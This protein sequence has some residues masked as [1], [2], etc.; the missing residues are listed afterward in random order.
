MVVERDASGVPQYEIAVYEDITARRHAEEALR[1]SE[2][3]FR[4]TFEL[5]DSGL[6][7]VSLDGRFLRVNRR[8]CEIFGYSE[9]ELRNLTAKEISHP[10]DRDLA[11]R[12]RARLLAGE[13]ESAR[14]DKRYFRKDGQ[15]P[16]GE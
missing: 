14:L 8:M 6:A 11:D 10:E 3:R 9:A 15:A 4:H 16:L 5:A 12:A 13:I 1:A 7:H 2:E